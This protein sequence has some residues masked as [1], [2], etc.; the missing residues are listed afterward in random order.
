[1][2]RNAESYR[3]NLVLPFLCETLRLSVSASKTLSERRYAFTGVR[4][5]ALTVSRISISETPTP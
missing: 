2:Q 5:R 3:I 1:M 4:P